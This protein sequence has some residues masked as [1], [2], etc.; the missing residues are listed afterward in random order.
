[1]SR[2]MPLRDLQTLICHQ[3]LFRQGVNTRSQILCPLILLQKEENAG[4]H[5]H[6]KYPPRHPPANL[7]CTR[8]RFAEVSDRRRI[9]RRGLFDYGEIGRGVGGGHGGFLHVGRSKTIGGEKPSA[10][11]RSVANQLD[12]RK[13]DPTESDESS[14]PSARLGLT[15][16]DRVEGNPFGSQRARAHRAPT[17]ERQSE[18]VRTE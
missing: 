5:H 16:A 13:R 9:R 11:R 10:S 6:R 3:E 7:G 14:S 18:R 1:M 15:T 8:I 4:Q 2:D 12:G 17:R